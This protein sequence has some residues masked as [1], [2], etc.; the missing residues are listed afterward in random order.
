MER[1][2]FVLAAGTIAAAALSASVAG[3]AEA[4]TQPGGNESLR[5]TRSSIAGIIDDLDFDP[6]AYGGH[7]VAAID[8]LRVAH[9]DLTQALKYR[10]KVTRPTQLAD[11]SIQQ[12]IGWIDNAIPT[13]QNDNTDYGGYKEKAVAALQQARRELTQALSKQ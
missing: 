3:V 13:L 10:N 5:Q 7:R 9:D 6:N 4:Q 8:A 12:Q 1:Q 2:R 11:S